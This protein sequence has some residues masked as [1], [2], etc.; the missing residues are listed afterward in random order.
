MIVPNLSRV[1]DAKV[2]VLGAIIL[3]GNYPSHI[4]SAEFSKPLNTNVF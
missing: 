1:L 3:S 4:L 2:K